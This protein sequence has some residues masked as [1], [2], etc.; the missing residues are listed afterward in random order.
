MVNSVVS[1]RDVD[2]SSRKDVVGDDDPKAEGWANESN[3]DELADR[4]TARGEL[5]VNHGYC[6]CS[7]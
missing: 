5:I 6:T 4:F 3:H 7:K 2:C 1:T